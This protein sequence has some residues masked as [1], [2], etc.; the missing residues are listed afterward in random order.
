[1]YRST[2]CDLYVR[3]VDSGTLILLED[4]VNAEH[5]IKHVIEKHKRD[6]KLLL[7]ECLQITITKLYTDLELGGN[8]LAQLLGIN[9]DVLA[10]VLAHILTRE[11]VRKQNG[12]LQS[13]IVSIT[14][15]K[16]KGTT[17]I[18]KIT[19]KEINKVRKL[20]YSADVDARAA[21]VL[22]RDRVD[23]LG[24]PLALLVVHKTV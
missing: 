12:S 17:K 8:K 9:G 16:S 24:R 10:G 7:A 4:A 14:T 1:M 11:A 15:K 3:E 20:T 19:A 5:V 13:L 21:K 18:G 2:T 22:L 23:V 6:V